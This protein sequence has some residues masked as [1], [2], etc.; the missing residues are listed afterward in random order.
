[1][2]PRAS[3]AMSGFFLWGSADDPVVKASA[4]VTQPN[5]VVAHRI[6]SSAR[7]DRSTIAWAQQNPNSEAK[8]RAAT[9]SRELSKWEF[10]PSSSTV[11]AGSSGSDDPPEADAPSGETA[12]RRRASSKRSA[13]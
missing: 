4:K 6:S 8:S 2:R 12:M 11:T 10:H 13:L 9:A 1:A 7:R 3:S 5:S